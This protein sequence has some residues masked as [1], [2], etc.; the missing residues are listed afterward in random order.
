MKKTS[1]FTKIGTSL[2]LVAIFAAVAAVTAFVGCKENKNTSESPSGSESI[3]STESTKSPEPSHNFSQTFAYD[4]EYH[5]RICSDAGCSETTDKEKHVFGKAEIITEPTA[6]M[7]GLRKLTCEKC[8]YEKNETIPATGKI[9]RS[10]GLKP[11]ITLDKTYDGNNVDITAESFDYEG[12]GEITIK[13]RKKGETEY[14]LSAPKEVGKYSVLITVGETGTYNEC[15][16]EFDFEI[17]VGEKPPVT[18]NYKNF[19]VTD[20]N[21]K[22]VSLSDFIGKPIV[23]NFWAYWCGP[24]GRELP[25]FDKLA[26]EYKGTV[27][28]LMVSV[29]LSK[30]TVKKYVLQNGYTFPLYFDDTESGSDA[31]SVSAIPVTVFITADGNIDEKLVGAISETTL[32]NHITRILNNKDNK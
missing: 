22:L 30:E 32:R 21:G 12:D 9:N 15:S 24:C 26:K 23:I 16:A 14:M 13:Y 5:Y 17:K 3:K 8:G 4:S 10:V 18:G 31:Y 11:G 29:D 25:H 2:F 20:V 1:S 27:E 6:D 7:S 19:T 28:F